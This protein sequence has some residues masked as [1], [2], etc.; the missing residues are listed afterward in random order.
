MA[1]SP[2]GIRRLPAWR[3]ISGWRGSVLAVSPAR[4][5]QRRES[6]RLG[7]RLVL[8]AA[9]VSRSRG[10]RAAAARVAHRGEYGP[11]VARDRVP[12]AARIAEERARLR[13]LKIAPADLALRIPVS[14]SPMG[15]VMHDGHPYS[16]PPDAIGLPGTLYLYRERVRIVAGR[17]SAEHERKFEPATA[18]SCPSIARSVAAVSASAPGAICSGSICSISAPP[19]GLS[20]RAHASAPADLD[21]RRRA[22]ARLLQTHG[23]A[24]ALRL[25][26]R[27]RR[28]GDRRRA[29]RALSRRRRAPPPFDPTDRPPTIAAAPLPREAGPGRRRR[30]Q[31]RSAAEH[32]DAAEHGDDLAASEAGHD[33]ADQDLDA[34]FKR[35]HLANARRVWRDLVQRAERESWSYRDFLT[36]GHRGDRASA[37]D[38]PGA[39]HA[40]RPLPFL[41]TIDDFNFTYNRRCGCTCS[42]RRSP[43]TS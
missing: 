41:K 33:G 34:L 20:H 36:S 25:R 2:N 12:P 37:A 6:G 42:A 18:R 22:A 11:P 14:V 29:H 15:V 10:S 26:A 35:L 7:E 23:D 17:F 3:S 40:A 27:P 4:E 24:P 30:P 28:A 39:T 32:L 8:Q 43:P 19:P 21:S 31:G 5:R 16:M 1:S 9:T 13:P 38:A